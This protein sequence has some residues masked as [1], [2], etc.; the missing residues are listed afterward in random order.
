MPFARIFGH[1][2]LKSKFPPLLLDIFCCQ[3]LNVYGQPLAKDGQLCN[4]DG[5]IL[6]IGAQ[7]SVIGGVVFA[8]DGQLL[9]VFYYP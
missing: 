1:L 9:K 2:L 6:S 3:L 4:S 7:P 8:F 5:Q